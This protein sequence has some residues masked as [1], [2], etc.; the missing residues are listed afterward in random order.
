MFRRVRRLEFE[1]LGETVEEWRAFFTSLVAPE[2]RT[3]VLPDRL[4]PGFVGLLPLIPAGVQSLTFRGWEQ[5]AVVD[6]EAAFAWLAA[7]PG[8][9]HLRIT[10]WHPRPPGMTAGVCA[11]LAN[12]TLV[13]LE[14]DSCE[15]DD[16]FTA[17]LPSAKGFER[18]ERIH[19]GDHHTI[20][21]HGPILAA[22]VRKLRSP[23]LRE[24]VI[25]FANPHSEE[26]IDALVEAPSTLTRL[27]LRD[28]TLPK[29][30]RARLAKTRTLVG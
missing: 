6:F 22:F 26:L 3:L 10:E 20:A 29:K 25:S 13:D 1:Y 28:C 14:V 16:D 5:R 30:T 17:R 9:V 11:V 24:L 15:E 23:R 4:A 2:L 19:I 7:R 12:P 21:N 27:E 18:L 8:L